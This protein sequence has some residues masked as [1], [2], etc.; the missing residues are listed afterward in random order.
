MLG[1]KL[2]GVIDVSYDYIAN[3]AQKYIDNNGV[4]DLNSAA[5]GEFV[6]LTQI[7]KYI[8]AE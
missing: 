6:Q 8:D 1:L 5:R 2:N 4:Y 7:L 3:A